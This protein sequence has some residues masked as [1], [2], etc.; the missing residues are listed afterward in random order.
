MI[1]INYQLDEQIHQGD[2]IKDVKHIQKVEHKGGDEYEITCIEFPL[3]VVLTQECDLDLDYKARKGSLTSNPEDKKLF[4][5][6]VAPVYPADQVFEGEHLR[7]L[8]RQMQIMTGRKLKHLQGPLKNNDTPR[9]YYLELPLKEDGELIIDFCH[10]FSID[11]ESLA[12]LK[13]S[14]FICSIKELFREDISL[15]FANYLARIRLP[16][17]CEKNWLEK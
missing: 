5:V 3:V 4:S 14:N 7:D 13:Q 16:R 6:L 15:R 2:I 12:K 11:V 8:H 9:Y 17:N 1:R 10:C